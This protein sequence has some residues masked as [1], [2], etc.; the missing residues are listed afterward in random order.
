MSQAQLA[1]FAAVLA[2]V[3]LTSVIYVMLVRA[4]YAA[5]KDR[6]IARPE[7]AYDQ[8]AWPLKTRL[9]GNSIASQFELPVLFFA[10]ALFAFQFGAAGWVT[11]ALAWIFVIT[12]IIHAVIHIGSN[13]VPRRFAAFFAG[14][15]AVVAMWAVIAFRVFTAPVG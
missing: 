15:L 10:A 11:A 5:L 9:V 2:Q 4:R 7:M 6:S 8:S 12:R 13:V 14:F 3:A 1:L